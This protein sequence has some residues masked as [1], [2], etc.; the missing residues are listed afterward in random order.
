M[1]SRKSPPQDRRDALFWAILGAAAAAYLLLVLSL[2]IANVAY[3]YSS[4]GLAAA[5]RDAFADPDIRYAMRLTLLSSTISATLS[6]LFAVPIGYFLS[7]SS[8]RGK[9]ILDA[10]MDLPIAL[11]PLVVG[12]SLLLVFQF[13]PDWAADGVVYQQP[14]VILAQFVV[15]AALAIRTMRVAFDGVDPE[16]EQIAL[17]QGASR[18]QALGWVVL[19]EV[20]GA[21]VTAATLA[22]ARSFGEFGPLLVFAGA[23]RGKT[24]VLSTT[25]FL[26][27][28]VGN[29]RGA[30]AVSL[31]MIAIAVLVVSATRILVPNDK[32][33]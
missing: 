31:V 11:P 29:L 25:I 14:A 28:S 23:T 12:L 26:E 30:V 9:A 4:P 1:S 32:Q 13:L 10:V 22:W 2:I 8:F 27:L 19:P 16:L 3:L 24:E 20:R 7:R 6:L 21:T 33:K 5:F 18:A 17:T 15:A